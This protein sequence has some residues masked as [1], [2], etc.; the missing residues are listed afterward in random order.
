M[1]FLHFVV[2]WSCIGLFTPSIYRSSRSS[3]RVFV[4]FQI[5]EFD[6][7][8]C[9][10]ATCVPGLGGECV[11]GTFNCRDGTEPPSEVSH[12]KSIKYRLIFVLFVVSCVHKELTFH[13]DVYLSA[14][15]VV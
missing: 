6:G 7:G 1:F 5:C 10:S 9:C 15:C 11:E 8:D 4:F 3:V 2:E 13:T 12:V 14:F